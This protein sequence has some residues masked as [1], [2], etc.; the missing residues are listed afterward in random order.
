MGPKT[1]R[2][3]KK[4]LKTTTKK[5]A[6]KKRKK[7]KKIKRKRKPKRKRK[8]KRNQK[9]KLTRKLLLKPY[10]I[11]VVLLL[12]LMVLK[13]LDHIQEEDTINTAE[14]LIPVK[15]NQKKVIKMVENYHVHA[16]RL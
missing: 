2:K 13:L 4:N 6:K 11:K 10:W 5:T 1:K 14:I 16:N 3:M 12:I 8:L 9:S 7:P 15:K